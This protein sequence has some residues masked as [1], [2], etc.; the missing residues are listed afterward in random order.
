[1]CT[2]LKEDGRLSV[3]NFVDHD[4]HLNGCNYW[5]EIFLQFLAQIVSQ[6][7]DENS[8]QILKFEQ[9]EIIGIIRVQKLIIF[10][11]L[12]RKSNYFNFDDLEI[13][14]WM[15]WITQN[16]I[17]CEYVVAIWLDR[18][19]YSEV[20][21]TENSSFNGPKTATSKGCITWDVWAKISI[22][23]RQF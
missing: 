14:W 7:Y 18:A 12:W 9:L 17:D 19:N 8:S 4:L 5:F 1:M 21:W 10:K 11:S 6:I 20:E 3:W 23:T 16:L 15:T 2:I 22:T 13:K